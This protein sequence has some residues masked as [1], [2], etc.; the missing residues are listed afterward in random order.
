[1]MRKTNIKITNGTN[2]GYLCHN[3]FKYIINKF[4]TSFTGKVTG[5]I[6]IKTAFRDQFILI[7]KSCSE[8]KLEYKRRHNL[9]TVCL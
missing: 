2:L 7:D 9:I 6:E 5:I 1:M 4:F 8:A 3:R